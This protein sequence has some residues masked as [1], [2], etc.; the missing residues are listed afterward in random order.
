MTL[1]CLALNSGLLM[2]PFSIAVEEF[3]HKGSREQA[4]FLQ[5]PSVAADGFCFLRDGL[6]VYI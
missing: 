2:G 6:L 5:K 4:L 1:A 3:T